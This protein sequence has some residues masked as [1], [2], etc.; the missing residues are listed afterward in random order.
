MIPQ[1]VHLK[2]TS[3][4][5]ESVLKDGLI[6]VDRQGFPGLCLDKMNPGRMRGWQSG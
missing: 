5:Y 6:S 2:G 3:G 4:H 1:D